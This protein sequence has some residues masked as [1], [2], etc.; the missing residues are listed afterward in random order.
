MNT[1]FFQEDYAVSE[2]ETPQAEDTTTEQETPQGD[3]VEEHPQ[4]DT[5]QEVDP[6]ISKLRKEAGDY[7]TRLR[8]QEQAAEEYKSQ[9]EHLR[10]SLSKTLG[11]EEETS[12]EDLIKQ[13]EE[14][15]TQANQRY[16]ELLQRVALSDAIGKAKAD[17]DLAVPFIKGTDKFG[18]LDPSADDYEAQVADLVAEI[19]EKYPKL[20]VQAAPPSSGN[21]TP[22][23]NN[24]HRELTRDDLRKLPP[25]EINKLAREGKL[26]HLMGKK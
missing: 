13:A 22:P 14:Q 3:Q 20:R 11:I 26:D 10:G 1:T 21:T 23:S 7:R 6:R 8:K 12:P 9:L 2:Q 4:E 5:T 19:V 15:A 17:P 18:T 16:N 25:E 24:E